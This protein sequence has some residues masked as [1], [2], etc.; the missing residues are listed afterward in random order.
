MSEIVNIIFSRRELVGIRQ[1]LEDEIEILKDRRKNGFLERDKADN[2]II[3]NE[4]ALKKVSNVLSKKDFD[5][6]LGENDEQII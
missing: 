4:S 3:I 2:R 1:S 6:Y 5:E